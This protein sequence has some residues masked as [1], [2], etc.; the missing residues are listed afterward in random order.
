[1]CSRDLGSL[2]REEDNKMPQERSASIL[3]LFYCRA[4]SWPPE[5][6]KRRAGEAELS[7]GVKAGAG[8]HRAP[9][10][11]PIRAALC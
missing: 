2:L 6:L 10:A 4:D 1:M 7:C 5:G 3:V 11:V 9:T 8:W